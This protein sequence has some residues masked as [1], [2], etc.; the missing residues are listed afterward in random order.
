MISERRD[1]LNYWPSFSDIFASLF[2][3]F[4][5]LFALLYTR[6]NNTTKAVEKDMEDLTKLV[7]GKTVIELDTLSMNFIIPENAFFDIKSSK[8]DDDG[9]KLANELGRFFDNFMSKN[10]RYRK[11]SI[12]IE[13][14][15]DRSGGYALN[16]SLSLARANN[17]INEMRKSM[18]DNMYDDIFIPVGYGEHKP[19]FDPEIDGKKDPRNRRVE[20]KIIPKF[21]EATMNIWRKI[22]KKKRGQT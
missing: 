21:N 1:E 13:G 12:I 19:K 2:F 5:I 22:L 18:Y 9:L 8:L 16:D 11:Y 7:E 4:L 14:H 6:A 20:I 3:I 15:A 17:V 10:N